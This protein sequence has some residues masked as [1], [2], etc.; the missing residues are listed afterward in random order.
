MTRRK[1]ELL[2][3]LRRQA[4]EKEARKSDPLGTD[5]LAKD[6][7]ADRFQAAGSGGPASLEARTPLEEPESEGELA[8][9]GPR[10][11]LP[12]LDPEVLAG[13]PWMPLAL[14]IVLAIP[15][16]WWVL[17]GLS[18]R[19]SVQAAG[20]GEDPAVVLTGGAGSPQSSP[21]GDA[22]AGPVQAAPDFGILVVTYD[23]S[24]ANEDLARRTRASLEE[25]G[26]PKV[27]AVLVPSDHPTHIE[28]FVGRASRPALLE[29]LLVRVQKFTLPGQSRQRPFADAVVR[30]HR[31]LA[32]Q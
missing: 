19:G 18:G 16:L 4:E 32:T 11:R 17:Q 22:S 31:Q 24:K 3:L 29:P 8:A 6:G 26:F 12:R 1:A 21:P 9:R 15:L 30:R 28:V 27:S 5:P 20:P 10:F 2:D 25:A 14:V 13:V 7:G 23:Y